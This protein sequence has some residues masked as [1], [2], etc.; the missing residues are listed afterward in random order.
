MPQKV[1]ARED[2]RVE[3]LAAQGILFQ[4]PFFLKNLQS[5]TSLFFSHGPWTHRRD[6]KGLIEPESCSNMLLY[7]SED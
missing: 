7:M 4:P 2:V 6:T 3:G 5:Q 1:P